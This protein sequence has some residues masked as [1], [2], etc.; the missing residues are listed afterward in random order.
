MFNINAD[1]T[2]TKSNDD[3]KGQN[4]RSNQITDRLT[5]IADE[6]EDENADLDALYKEAK[7]LKAE[8]NALSKK[9]EQR[10]KILEGIA[11]G[12]IPS[13]TTH[14][15][16]DASGRP[17]G[18]IKRDAWKDKVVFRS[19][20]MLS[21]KYADDVNA[22]KCLR[23][24][25]TGNYKSLNEAEMRAVTPESGGAMLAPI[26]LAR[27]IDNLRQTN[28]MEIF[29]PTIVMMNTGEFKIPII[30]QLPA[31]VMHTPGTE[32]TPDNPV[33]E[34]ATLNAKTMMVLVEVANELLDDSAVAHDVILQ[35]CTGAIG[36][37]LLQQ[38]LYGTGTP[39]EMKGVTTYPDTAFAA[40]GDMSAEPDLSRLATMARMAI[41]KT[42]G[43][44]DG[45]LYDCALEDRLDSRNTIGDAA[46]PS[47]AFWT[48]YEDG[49][50][51]P[52]PSVAKGDMFFLQADSL[53]LG[54]RDN[55]RIEVDRSSAFNSNNTKFRAILRADIYANVAK[56]VYYNGIPAVAPAAG[57][58][59]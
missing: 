58:Q 9:A 59:G 14:A 28:W 22:D 42:N 35:A 55:M 16:P 20:E 19:G 12:A 46:L 38:I 41:L 15:F 7:K 6:I 49:R 32:Q 17:K 47:R 3:H 5:Q 44:M 26:V 40:A 4:I 27:V 25:I 1:S 53:Y 24:A 30:D 33:I 36:N 31:A 54:M 56:M 43:V 50:T 52:H 21:D 23:A 37:K 13:T 39:P 8:R 51:L 29:R 34:A 2:V 18:Q 57:T 48:L 11:N 45:I 10:R